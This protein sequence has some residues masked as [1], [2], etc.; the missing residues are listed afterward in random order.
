MFGFKVSR[1]VVSVSVLAVMLMTSGAVAEDEIAAGTEPADGEVSYENYPP[2]DP[3]YVI[4]EPVGTTDEGIAVGE[5]DPTGG[6][7]VTDDGEVI[8]VE[9]LPEDGVGDDGM[10]EDPGTGLGDPDIL[11]TYDGSV[12]DCGGC[13]YQSGGGPE[14]PMTPGTPAAHAAA[15]G[16]PAAHAVI[17]RSAGS[18]TSAAKDSC[19]D[20]ERYV[21]WMCDWQ[22]GLG[23]IGQ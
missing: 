16:T 19:A 23:L 9:G 4:D 14:L 18:V 17:A 5:P 1:P 6:G 12:S 11:V 21:A 7:V 15:A 10:G 20:P 3:I 13:E 2:E 22:K 8:F